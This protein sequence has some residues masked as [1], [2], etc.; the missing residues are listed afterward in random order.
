MSLDRNKQGI[1]PK[2]YPGKTGDECLTFR[3]KP[4]VFSGLGSD[5]RLPTPPNYHRKLYWSLPA[6]LA[7]LP[8]DLPGS[9]GNGLT[10][11]LPVASMRRIEAPDV[12]MRRLLA[13][14]V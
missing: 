8:V 11:L 7:A 2:S 10:T 4:R 6:L 12:G 9:Q 13:E 3:T 5:D 14:C 1:Q